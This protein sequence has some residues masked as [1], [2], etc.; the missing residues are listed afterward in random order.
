M[1][2]RPFPSLLLPKPLASLASTLFKTTKPTTPGTQ[3]R[4]F[5]LLNPT[6]RSHT[7]RIFD[8]VR[9]PNDLHTLTMLNAADNRTLITMWS[10]KWCATCQ[11]IRPLIL[12]MIEEEK[13]GEREGGLGY[14][15]VEM[16]STLIED[17]PVKFRIASM[18]T[19]LAFSRQEA[20]FDTRLTK[21]EDMKNEE[22]LRE[23]LLNE[24]K[25]GGRMGGGGGGI[26]GTAKDETKE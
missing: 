21:P 4:L 6:A 14:V 2:V 9:Q 22:F 11:T 1:L 16:D 23:W 7:N 3:T 13:V 10:A 19:L 5:S 8:P 26:F 20:Q 25:R 18:P 17:L 12:K 24:A 15:E